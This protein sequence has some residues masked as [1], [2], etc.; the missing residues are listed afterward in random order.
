MKRLI[1]LL[2]ISLVFLSTV[3]AAD[4]DATFSAK[5]RTADGSTFDGFLKTTIKIDDL[6]A[7]FKEGSKDEIVHT[8]YNSIIPTQAVFGKTSDEHNRMLE[9]ITKKYSDE[10]GDLIKV[11]VQTL[12]NIDLNDR[13]DGVFRVVYILA[14][15]PQ[16]VIDAAKQSGET[17][18][19][20]DYA[21]VTLECSLQDPL[22]VIED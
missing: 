12:I 1:V 6:K 2:F 14:F 4:L 10:N 16:E 7:V 8:I 19:T 3:S 5:G 15:I 13:K 20:A 22:L 17:L 21:E 9:V 11:P 18:N